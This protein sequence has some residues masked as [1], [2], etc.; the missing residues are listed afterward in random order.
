MRGLSLALLFGAGL[1][2][3]VGI[4]VSGVSGC[5]GNPPPPPTAPGQSEESAPEQGSGGP[6]VESEIGAL[7][8][9]K[10]KQSFE[11]AASKLS[12]CF[13]RGTERLPYLSGEVRFV[14]RIKKDGA[15]RFAFVKDSNLGDRETEECMLGIFKA[16]SWPK[17]KGGEGL[18]ENSFTFEPGA[19][20]RPPVVWS[21]E[22]LGAPF[23]KARGALARCRA[24]AGVKPGALKATMYV[25]T[26]G[27]PSAV[28]VSSADEKGEAAI[29]CVVSTLKAVTFPSPGSYAAKVSLTID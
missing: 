24:G 14:I 17:P 4:G 10:V 26:D 5:G 16:I 11:R 9:F 13:N 28:G 6:S 2:A 15:A 12:A 23:R 18:A 7:D 3:S 20:E 8:E 27:K 21:E 25:S 29:G 1:T 19:D 22:Q